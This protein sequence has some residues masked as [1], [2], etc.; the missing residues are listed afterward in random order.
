MNLFLSLAFVLAPVPL[1]VIDPLLYQ[2]SSLLA[3]SL[4]SPNEIYLKCLVCQMSIRETDGPE[5]VHNHGMA[6]SRECESVCSDCFLWS[7]SWFASTLMHG[8]DSTHS[9]SKQCCETATGQSH[10]ILMV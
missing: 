2:P 1:Q 6:L 5:R 4:Q 3:A 10:N 9:V 7:S 8:D